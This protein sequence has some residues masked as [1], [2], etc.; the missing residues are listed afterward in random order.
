[1]IF[2]TASKLENLFIYV[3]DAKYE[4]KIFH[5]SAPLIFESHCVERKILRMISLIDVSL[6]ATVCLVFWLIQ[7]LLPPLNTIFELLL[8]LHS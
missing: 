3:K 5:G 2:E 7:Y 8:Y 6:P 4:I 1:M